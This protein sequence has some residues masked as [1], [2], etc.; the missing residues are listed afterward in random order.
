[1]RAR[2]QKPTVNI[3]TRLEELKVLS[4]LA[5]AGILSSLESQGVFSKLEAAG[6]FS[7]AEKLLPLSTLPALQLRAHA[8]RSQRPPSRAPAAADD[9]KF[10]AIAEDLLNVL[11]GPSSS[12]VL[13]LGGEAGLIYLVR[14]TVPRL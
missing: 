10:L 4:A 3:L 6:A 11:S 13:R 5:D 9:L 14:T 12:R 2:A 7:T 1:M 8:Q